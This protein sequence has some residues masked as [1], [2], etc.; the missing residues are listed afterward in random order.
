MKL[1]ARKAAWRNLMVCAINAALE[2]RLFSLC[3]SEPPKQQGYGYSGV[4][5]DFNVGGLPAQGYVADSACHGADGVVIR[6]AIN[7]P[8]LMLVKGDAYASGCLL[9]EG[10]LRLSSVLSFSCRNDLKPFLAGLKVE[11]RGYRLR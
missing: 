2:Q 11:A 1:S 6:A 7:S 4:F 3:P 8:M 10:N 5:F 9:R